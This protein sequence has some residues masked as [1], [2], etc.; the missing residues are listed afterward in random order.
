MSTRFSQLSRLLALA[1]GVTILG[2]ASCG[3]DGGDR[4][5]SDLA[6]RLARQSDALVRTLDRGDSCAADARARALRAAADAAIAERRVPAGLRSELRRRVARLDREVVCRRPP[7]PSPPPSAPPTPPSAGPGEREDEGKDEED[8][9]DQDE[10]GKGGDKD[11]GKGNGN[12]PGRGKGNEK[13]KD[14]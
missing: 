9:R 2:L 3:G 7:P 12:N 1:A 5:P 13:G 6:A 14:D 4:L 10:R 8:E 11:D